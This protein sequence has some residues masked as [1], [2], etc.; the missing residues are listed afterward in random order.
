MLNQYLMWG[1]FV[2]FIIAM[3]ILDLKVLQRRSHVMP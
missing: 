1:G 2:L 3:L